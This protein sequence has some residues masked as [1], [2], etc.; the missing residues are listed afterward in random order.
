LTSVLEVRSQLHAP[1]ALFPGESFP[2]AVRWA[3]E[4][5]WTLRSTEKSLTPTRSQT[6]AVQLVVSRY[7]DWAVLAPKGHAMHKTFP[8][9]NRILGPELEPLWV[10]TTTWWVS[11]Y[12]NPYFCPA[13]TRYNSNQ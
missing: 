12:R 6:P 1:A 4:P 10:L 8:F 13:A 5:L 7:T 2:A 3:P 11:V 9:G